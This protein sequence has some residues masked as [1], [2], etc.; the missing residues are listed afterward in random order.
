MHPPHFIAVLF[1]RNYETII[2]SLYFIFAFSFVAVK[3]YS[4]ESS[5]PHVLNGSRTTYSA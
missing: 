4:L 1:G 3:V 5:F 2:E